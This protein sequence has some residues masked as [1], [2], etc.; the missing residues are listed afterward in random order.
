MDR[1]TLFVGGDSGPMHIAATTDVPIAALFGPTMPVTWAPWR[2]ARLP[3]A[4]IE[5]GP[6]PCRPCDQRVCEPGDFRCMTR[7]D[8]RWSW[9]RPSG[10]WRLRDDDAKAGTDGVHPHRPV[11]RGCGSTCR[12][13]GRAV[14]AAAIVW[15]VVAARDGRRPQTPAFLPL[16]V[17]AALTLVSAAFSSDPRES[18][19]DSKQLLMFHGAHRRAFATG[20]RATDDGRDHCGR[21]GRRPHRYRAVCDRPKRSRSPSD[22]PARPLDDVSGVDARH[23]RRRGPADLHAVAECLAACGGA[24]AAGGPARDEHAQ[25]VDWRVPG[26]FVAPRHPELEARDRGATARAVA[27]LV[28]PA[29]YAAARELD[30]ESVRPGDRDEGNVESARTLSRTIRC[31]ASDPR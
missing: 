4:A 2:P 25:R 20:S 7:S 26:D 10:C 29:E 18:F 12:R 14:S 11:P 21:I 5:T 6:L 31:S 1:A 13:A 28:A 24:G 17:Y 15:L 8:P 16:L 3:F 9:P 23:M 22:G 30:L 27:S 19:I